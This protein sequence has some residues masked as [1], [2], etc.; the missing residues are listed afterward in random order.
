MKNCEESHLI[1]VIASVVCLILIEVIGDIG[2]EMGWSWFK[3]W[4][5][6]QLNGR[7]FAFLPILGNFFFFGIRAHP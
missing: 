2:Y 7:I 4:G 5:Y 6:G 1:S 3:C